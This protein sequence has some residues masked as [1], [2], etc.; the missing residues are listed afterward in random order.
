MPSS[1]STSKLAAPVRPLQQLGCL[2]FAIACLALLTT[3]CAPVD[4][5]DPQADSAAKQFSPPPGMAQLYVY[6]DDN[7]VIN[8]TI[9]VLLDGVKLGTTQVGTYLAVPVEPGSHTVVAKGENSD[10]VSFEAEAGENVFI[11]IGV[12]LGVVTNRARLMMMDEKAGREAVVNTRLVSPPV[13]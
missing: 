13:D 12:G 4:Y 3:A 5:A 1:S 10:E 6:R 8:T 11:Q 2:A 9:D 7:V